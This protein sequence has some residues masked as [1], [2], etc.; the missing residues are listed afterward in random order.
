LLRS[1]GLLGALVGGWV[2]YESNKALQQHQTEVE[3]RTNLAT[4]A[5]EAF[6]SAIVTGEHVASERLANFTRSQSTNTVLLIRDWDRG[7]DQWQADNARLEAQLTARFAAHREIMRSWT[8]YSHAVTGFVRLATLNAADPE[9]ALASVRGYLGLAN[10]AI[11]GIDWAAILRGRG[12]RGKKATLFRKNYD[13]VGDA[14]LARGDAFLSDLVR[15][16]PV[17]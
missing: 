17:V 2:T 16:K 4:E 11:Q 7:F 1:R 3:V 13:R 6:T 15:L 9:R 8:S 5:A 12:D 14:L 10:P